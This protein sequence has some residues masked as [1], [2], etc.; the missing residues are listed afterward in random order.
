M[1]YTYATLLLN[2]TGAEI[3]ESNL[4]AILE[5]ADAE[6]SVSRVK[7]TIAALEGVDVD[8]AAGTLSTDDPDPAV[9]HAD[10]LDSGDPEGNGDDAAA[11]GDVADDAG[12][13][14]A[15]VVPDGGRSADPEPSDAEPPE[16]E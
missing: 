12:D 9:P 3:N 1:K 14:D 10:G 7:A 11:D 16:R 15:A 4:V 8:A 5:A 2:E 13:D 6:V